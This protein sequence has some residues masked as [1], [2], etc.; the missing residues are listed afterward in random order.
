MTTV[1]TPRGWTSIA[2]FIKSDLSGTEIVNFFL[3]Y[4]IW[5][6]NIL[7]KRLNVL[8]GCN[9]SNKNILLSFL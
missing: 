3:T 4:T 1:Y 6:I 8:I 5:K 2:L 9:I 7:I